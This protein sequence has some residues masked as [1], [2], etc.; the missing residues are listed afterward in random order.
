LP[1]IKKALFLRFIHPLQTTMMEKGDLTYRLNACA[2]RVSTTLGI[3]NMEYV[4]CRALAIE[5]NLAGIAFQRE[6]WLP[7]HYKNLRIAYRRVDFLCEGKVTIEVKAKSQLTDVDFVQ[8]INTLQQLNIPAGLLYNFGTIQLQFKHL[9][10]NRFQP[11]A[12]TQPI[13]PEMVGEPSDDLFELRNYIPAWVLHK[14]Q[15]DKRKGKK[16]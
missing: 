4:Y 3:G 15:Y 1:N 8:A 14:M 6:V 5:L 9:F 7:I 2:M 16:V 12:L 10:N 11:D 13:T